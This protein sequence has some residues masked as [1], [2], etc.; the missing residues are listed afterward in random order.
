MHNSHR[1]VKGKDR[2]TL[3]VHPNDAGR[4]R[5]DDGATVRVTSAVGSIELPLEV[6]DAI[7]PEPVRR[8]AAGVSVNDITDP[9]HFDTLTG[10]AALNG[11][12]VRVAAVA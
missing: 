8:E 10:V 3:F 2:C 5:L 12:P 1:L 9:G 11:L 6:T 4:L 7:M